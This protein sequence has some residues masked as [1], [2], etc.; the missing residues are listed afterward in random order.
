MRAVLQRVGSARVE[1]AGE[2][3]G[4]IGHGLL[5]LLG[6]SGGDG[7]EEAARLAGKIA[8]LR[9]FPD[10]EGRLELSLLD[11]G[12]EALVVSQ[13]T[14]WADCNKGRRPSYA[15][16]AKGETA[17]PLYREFTAQLAAKGVK[18]A[19]GRFGAMMEVS[20]TNSGPITLLLDTEK[21]F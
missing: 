4:Q 1:V 13:F 10:A 16:A 12:G 17:E 19:N 14:L 7:K 15:R 11:V 18:T 21:T 5:I 2:T 6:V 8:G 3:V 9:L 20:L